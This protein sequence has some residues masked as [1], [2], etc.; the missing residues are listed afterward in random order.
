MLA[1]GMLILHLA[2]REG[3]REPSAVAMMPLPLVA[4][5]LALDVFRGAMG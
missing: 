1:L 3:P 2:A 4:V 5:A